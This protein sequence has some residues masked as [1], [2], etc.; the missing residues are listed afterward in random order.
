MS[1][2]RLTAPYR[3]ARELGIDVRRWLLLSRLPRFVRDAI[4]WRRA[5]GRTRSYYPCLSDWSDEAGATRSPYFL[6][7]L[8]VARRVCAASPEHHIDVGS[9]IDGF[10]AHLAVFRAVT[11]LDVRP[12]HSTIPNVTF[13]Q[14]DLMAPLS[15]ELVAAADSVS[16]LHA[17]EHF[18]LGRYGDPID[19]NGHLKGFRAL[20]AMLRPGG[21]LYVS[22]PIG[23]AA[24]EF[25][26]HRVFDPLEPLGWPTAVPLM[27]ER[28]DYIDADGVLHERVALD[29][30]TGAGL[31][32]LTEACGIYTF[33]RTPQ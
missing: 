5:G 28:F 10:V 32:K 18:G 16:S 22:F 14:C 30:S 33:L 19:P 2:T 27:L 9:R 6:Q 3:L 29:A 7:D 11:V 25:N 17:L 13:I 21:R 15:A 4:A 31:R 26:A 20:T 8:L 12:L 1:P 24:V 23:S